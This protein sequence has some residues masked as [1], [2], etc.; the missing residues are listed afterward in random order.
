MILEIYA[1]DG[2]IIRTIKN[3]LNMEQAPYLVDVHIIRFK[4]GTFG[5]FKSQTFTVMPE[6]E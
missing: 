3:I 2:S 4:D 5:Y 1:K 6:A